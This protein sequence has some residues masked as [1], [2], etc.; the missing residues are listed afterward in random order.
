M[1]AS[2][3][4]RIA[5]YFAALFLAAMG[6][7]FF[8][9]YVGIPQFGL[10]GASNQRLS[11]AIRNLELKADYQRA[12]ITEG[13]KERRG[14]VL[15]I[16]EN[17][18]LTK[19]LENHEP[20][21]QQDVERIFDRL[22]RAY[23]DRY[24]RLVIVDPADG[25]ILASS[26][27]DEQGKTFQQLELI[28]SAAQPGIN[29]L[30]EHL[31]RKAGFDVVIVR[32]I[33]ALAADG[34]PGSDLVGILIAFIDPQQFISEGFR[35]DLPVSG[36]H[37]STLLLG[38]A[39]QV[40][41]STASDRSSAAIFRQN[42]RVAEGFEGTLQQTDAGGNAL[43][44]VYRH[45]QLSGSQG[46][47]LV[48]H[49]SRDEALK[50]LASGVST[51]V[52]IGLLLTVAALLLISLAA[53]RLTRPLKL[54]SRTARQLGKG[55]LS[56][57]AF[58]QQGESREMVVLAEAFDGMA[59]S[60]QQTQQMLESR[61]LERTAEL[62][63]SEDRY[64]SLF[65][66]NPVA[67]LV[68]VVVDRQVLAVN[69]AFVQLLGYAREEIVGQPVDLAID[70]GE[71]ERLVSTVSQLAATDG[72]ARY[73][74]VWRY[75]HRYG[76]L[77]DLEFVSQRIDYE[78]RDARIVSIQDVTER[79]RI[80]AA[81]DQQY[82]HL[83]AL[84]EVRT[85][86]AVAA[87]ESAEQANRA[88]SVFLANMS[89]ELRTPLNAVL[90][91]S[92]LLQRD[93]EIAEESQKKLAI[94]NRSGQHLLSLI[95]DVLEI[96]RI[97]A[98][99]SATV[100]EA[101]DLVDLLNSIEEMIRVRADG[102]G[103]IFLVE[104]A[105]DLPAFVE[106]DGPHLKQVLINLLGNAVKYTEHG[107]VSLRVSRCNEEPAGEICFAVADTGPGIATDEQE[108]VFQPFYQ[109][110]IGIAKGDGTGLGLAISREYTRMMN[111]RL[112]V[113]S[114]SGEGSV[115]ILRLPLPEAT[116]AVLQTATGH[117]IGLEAGQGEQRILV[118][119]DKA[120]NRE[121]VQQLLEI[122]GFVVRTA[123]N[124]QQAIDTF[125]QWQP[126]FIWMDMRMPVLDGYAATQQIRAL[127]GGGTVKIVALTASAFEEDRSEIMA[128]GCDDLVR[129][130]L[131]EARLFAVMGELLGLRYRYA[132]G[133]APTPTPTPTP[134]AELDLST[135]P[136]A[137]V[138]ELGCAAETL[139][140]DAAQHIVAKITQLDAES[141]Q[142]L[143]ALING[144]RFD[145]IADICGK[146]GS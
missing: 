129:K 76:L 105:A 28:R 92:Q 106:G 131:E 136:A 47:T 86:E 119:D 42:S 99:R 91:F 74:G 3:S 23:P 72:K 12:Q 134:A 96:S 139:D 62:Q 146:S 123:D 32:Q 10:V 48:H 83:E 107:S 103:L 82:L 45:L 39:G 128:A 13:F 14:D 73:R 88:K 138:A 95:N 7:L 41:A 52:M 112:T 31:P 94:I 80:R 8:F 1:N 19:Q 124:G 51:L 22:Q 18:V 40:L 43:V 67:Q 70:D 125:K 132:E 108:R 93:S 101:F 25:R 56:A 26:V 97:E 60:V 116:A 64:R 29:E 21:V 145:L 36:R 49:L 118:V 109:T 79:E 130:P 2:F 68:Y 63:K 140:M 75:R 46:W 30:I 113:D 20:S 33:H 35:D 17:K 58:A 110:E 38:S 87:K 59:E 6:L 100:T 120:D 61:V 27:A 11:E 141:G 50:G 143:E 81:L 117:V 84:V 77:L 98:G 144:Y 71:R 44:V 102:K 78:G 114:R 126:C 111:G 37:G 137:L 53:R 89:H 57:R 133:P 9:W 121:L 15:I 142:R 34:Y 66:D 115:F 24:Q 122:T 69:S 90:G 127:P 54:L 85:R 16:A 5:A 104:H 4:S 65:D 55:D 135:L